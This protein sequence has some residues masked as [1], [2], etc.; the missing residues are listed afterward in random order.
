[1]KKTVEQQA[2]IIARAVI[3]RWR[4]FPWLDDDPSDPELHGECRGVVKQLDRIRCERDA[5]H[6]I[7]RVFSSSFDNRRDQFTPQSCAVVGKELYAEFKR[8]GLIW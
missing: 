6:A 4:P 1:M 2:E 3:Y 7:A 8:A 5:A